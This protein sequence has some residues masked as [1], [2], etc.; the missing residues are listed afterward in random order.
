MISLDVKI[1]FTF[2]AMYWNNRVE[3]FDVESSSRIAR[4]H[5]QKA[6]AVCLCSDIPCDPIYHTGYFC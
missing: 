3:I 6:A 5:N 4:E 2:I 1:I